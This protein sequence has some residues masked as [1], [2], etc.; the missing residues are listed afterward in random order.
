MSD[1]PSSVDVIVSAETAAQAS[2]SV[3]P[4]V[5]AVLAVIAIGCYFAY[6]KLNRP[7]VL[8][9]QIR[10]KNLKALEKQGVESNEALADLDRL[11]TSVERYAT[12]KS[13]T[14]T[15]TLRFLAPLNDKDRIK[16]AKDMY[17]ALYKIA[18]DVE[19]QRLAAEFKTRGA[20]VKANSRLMAGILKR[21]G[22]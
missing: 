18:L 17:N 6:K 13:L 12:K 9:K 10:K 14:G 19:D 8:I 22:V 1:I 20:N 15:Q 2:V 21:A 16:T 4:Y 3:W 7:S 5:L 11:L